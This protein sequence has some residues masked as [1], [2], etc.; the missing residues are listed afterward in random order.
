MASSIGVNSVMT[1]TSRVRVVVVEQHRQERR[2]SGARPEGVVDRDRRALL[3]LDLGRVVVGVLLDL[4]LFLL[5]LDELIPVV[6]ELAVV[7]NRP[8]ASAAGVVEHDRGGR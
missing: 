5:A 8:D 6:D 1:R 7:L 4:L 3:L 2:A